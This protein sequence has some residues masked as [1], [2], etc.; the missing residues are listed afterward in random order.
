MFG[1]LRPRPSY[2]NV[3]S[4]LAVFVALGGSAYAGATLSRNS[5]HSA[6]IANGSVKRVDIATNAIDTTKV[7]DGSL[8]LR[9]FK[10]GQLKAGATG[11]QGPQGPAG[12]KGD[13]GATHVVVR[14][15]SGHGIQRTDCGPGEVAT[16]GG[17]HSPDGFVIASIPNGHPQAPFAPNGPAT[18]YTANQSWEARA[19]KVN[20]SNTGTITS[21]E[22]ADIT[23][24]VVCAA[25]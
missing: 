18:S 12:P 22:D 9:D 7:A 24:W 17:A 4:T 8:L 13:P 6:Q 2:A 3:M 15:S 19:V 25:P 5:V 14:T 1:K 23:T 11:P 16:G 21:V 20:V 10:T